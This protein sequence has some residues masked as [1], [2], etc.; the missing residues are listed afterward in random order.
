MI[1]AIRTRLAAN[2]WVVRPDEMRIYLTSVTLTSSVIAVDALCRGSFEDGPRSSILLDIRMA[3]N[4]LRAPPPA[5]PDRG[6]PPNPGAA[7]KSR[8][9]GP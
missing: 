1:E 3:V 2:P 4:A 8:A 9:D 7:K 5:R 6:G